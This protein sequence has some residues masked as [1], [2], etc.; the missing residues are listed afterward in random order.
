MSNAQDTK[1]LTGWTAREPLQIDYIDVPAGSGTWEKG[2]RPHLEYRD[3]GLAAATGGRMASQHIRATGRAGE[4]RDDWHYHDLDFQFFYVLRGSITIETEHGDVV[5]LGPGASGYQPPLYRHREYDFTEDYEVVAI[6]APATFET[7]HGF[8]APLPE[9]A[10]GLA[11]DRRPVYTHDTD[12][13]YEMGAGPRK[14][15]KY[16]DLGT[17]EPTDGR[18]HIHVVRATGQPGEGT[19]W[20]Y[21]TMAQWFMIL[22]GFSDIRVEDRPRQRL[23]AGD[24]MCIGAGPEMRHNVAPYSGDYAVLEMC[25]PAEYETI[26]VEAPDGAAE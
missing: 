1:W 16:R 5:V 17:R 3:L 20:H 21:H 10:T 13:A 25:V 23:R 9:R 6:Y 19:G 26:A 15:F 12:D 24:T 14:F 8:D 7:V 2:L 22:D 18:I 4:M 11:A